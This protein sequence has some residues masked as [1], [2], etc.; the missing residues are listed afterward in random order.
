MTEDPEKSCWLLTVSQGASV[1]AAI[2]DQRW[3]R[4]VFGHWMNPGYAVSRWEVFG[5]C[6]LLHETGIP[7]LATMYVGVNW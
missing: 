4:P 5:I 3:L 6:R 7:M 2:L 1:C